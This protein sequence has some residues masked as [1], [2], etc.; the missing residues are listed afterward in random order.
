MNGELLLLAGTARM[1]AASAM[2]RLPAASV[3][4]AEGATAG[5]ETV[6]RAP[7]ARLKR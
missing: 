2:S 4:T 1:E 6:V 5:L 3:R 7:V